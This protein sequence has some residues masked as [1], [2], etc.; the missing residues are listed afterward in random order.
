M[1]SSGSGKFGTYRDGEN[2]LLNSG[3]NSRSVGRR[4]SNNCPDK[5]EFIKL[6]DVTLS[7]YFTNFSSLPVKDSTIR[8]DSKLFL[9]RLVVIDIQTGKIIGNLPT[10]LNYLLIC[11]KSGKYYEG[12][13]VSSGLIPLPF[14]V[15]SLYER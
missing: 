13:V 8:L 10:D 11:L 14:I 7:E 3:S 12:N 1:G 2:S 15:V 9:N 5:L 4:E 6:E